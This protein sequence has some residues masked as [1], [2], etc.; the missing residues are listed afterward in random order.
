MSMRATRGMQNYWDERARLNAAYYV[1]TSLGY[2]APDMDKF[3]ETG[4]TVVRFALDEAPI[5][6]TER[7]TAV[8]IGCGLG[9]ICLALADRF[10]RVV[11]F[12]ISA[13]ML[14]R[15]RELVSDPKV[16][17]R[18]TDGASLPGLSDNTVD[19]VVTFTVFQHI[20][21]VEVIRTYV[22]EVGRVLR[23]G[24]VFCLQWNSTP[25]ALSWRARRS[26]M[27]VVQAFGFGD[28]YGRDRPQFLGSRV[29]V[30]NMGGML[31]D[32]GLELVEVR[33][34]GQLFTWAWARKAQPTST[35]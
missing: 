7:G 22:N 20:P 32:A 33:D 1:D 25:G 10:D 27:A 2:D 8:E 26:A 17:T 6:P 24:G 31:R 23:P 15:S 34:P 30:A 11:G 14:A 21:R 28:K 3:V 9:R 16:E 5:Q 4:R 29:P 18:L 19:M 13:E 12:D 35:G